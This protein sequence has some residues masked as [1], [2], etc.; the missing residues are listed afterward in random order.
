MDDAKFVITVGRQFGS[1]GREVG[2]YIADKLGVAYYDKELL[3]EASKDSGVCAEFFE[4]ADERSPSCFDNLFSFNP[5]YTMSPIMGTQ[6]PISPD[7][8]YA[9]QCKVIMQLA[10][11]RSCVIVG[12]SADYVLRNH[13]CCINVFLHASIQSRVRR[14][15]SRRDCGSEEEA[16]AIARKKDKLR[17]N[18]YNYYTEKV[19]GSAASYDLSVD[20]THLS[21]EE[22]GDL[23]IEY[24]KMRF[25]EAFE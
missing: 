10:K 5:G 21:V 15:M 17:A 2:R 7:N 6:S 23:I 22:V 20:T 8:I 9:M 1:G 19:W 18:F 11:E 4:R 3:A 12:R 25:Q 16:A 14:I 13:P 24:C